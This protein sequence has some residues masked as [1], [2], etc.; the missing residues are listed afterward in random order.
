MAMEDPATQ[1]AGVPPIRTEE[2]SVCKDEFGSQE[3]IMLQCGHYFHG[4]CGQ[5]WYVFDYSRKYI[6]YYLISSFKLFS[7]W[8][9]FNYEG[10]VAS[11]LAAAPS[12]VDNS[13]FLIISM[14]VELS[15]K[16]QMIG[17]ESRLKLTKLP[18]LQH[19]SMLMFIVFWF[20][21]FFSFPRR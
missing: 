14:A 4:G 8:L 7:I 11:N 9:I 2:C 16:R 6:V 3:T 5:R 13:A 15:T 17:G 12:A 20:A 18:M 1:R 10:M 21:Y 19:R